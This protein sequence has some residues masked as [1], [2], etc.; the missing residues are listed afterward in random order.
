MAQAPLLRIENLHK[1]FGDL[2]VLKG[3]SLDVAQGEVVALIGASGSGKTTML[4]CINVLEEFEQGTI[5]LD[6][7]PIG[8]AVQGSVRR[9]LPE[10]VV[11]AQRARISMVF[12]S[13]NLFPH[14]T[15]AENVAL[16]QQHVRR[17][18]RREARVAA[19][20]WLTRVGL[21]HRIDHYPYQLSGGQQ[22]RVAIARALAMEPRLLLFDEVTSALDPELVEEV[23]GV[24]QD[25]AASGM[26]MVVVSHELLFVHDVAHRAVFMDGGRIAAQGPPAELFRNPE[27][28]RLQSFLGRFRAVFG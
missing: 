28:A 12:Q 22:Q 20:H 21:A 3:V 19:E 23:L 18:G 7:E 6:G 15:A 25:L 4:R 11:A 14:L 9:R 1:S 24:M 27:N 16:G 17:I 10:R 2:E 5:A 26:T 13:Y 8:Y